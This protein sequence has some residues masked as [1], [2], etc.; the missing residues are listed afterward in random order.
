MIK[1]IFILI[2]V[3]TLTVFLLLSC[4]RTYFHLTEEVHDNVAMRFT[5]GTS[6]F[7]P[8]RSIVLTGGKY[9]IEWGDSIVLFVEG[10]AKFTGV[11]EEGIGTLDFTE[12]ARFYITLQPSLKAGRYNTRYKAIC[13]IINSFTYGEGENLFTCQSGEVVIDSLRKGKIYGVFTG[14]YLNTSN[15]HLSVKGDIKAGRK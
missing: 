8:G 14:E 12:T 4:K 15:K 9:R 13:E 3:L 5:T 2:P 1:K 6:Y 10:K 11:G 7:E